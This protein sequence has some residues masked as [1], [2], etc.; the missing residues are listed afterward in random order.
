[1]LYFSFTILLLGLKGILP[2]TLVSPRCALN[3]TCGITAAGLFCVGVAWAPASD[4]GSR[5][6]SPVTHAA[7][8][9]AHDR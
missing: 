7:W 2:S 1:M 3:L 8:K 5:R 4:N 9:V 6:A